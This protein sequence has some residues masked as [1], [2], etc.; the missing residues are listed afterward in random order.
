MVFNKK[1]L[2]DIDDSFFLPETNIEEVLSL[3]DLSG[4]PNAFLTEIKQDQVYET[5]YREL[6]KKIPKQS[7]ISSPLPFDTASEHDESKP[8]SPRLLSLE[9]DADDDIIDNETN[10]NDDILSTASSEH[11]DSSQDGYDTDLET[12][13]IF[14]LFFQSIIFSSNRNYCSR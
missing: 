2:I 13:E 12:G 1:Y 9:D 11:N 6:K 4:V 3:P 10:I 5:I 7:S 8:L 14:I